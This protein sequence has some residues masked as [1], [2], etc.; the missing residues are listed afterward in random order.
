MGA[1]LAVCLST[2]MASVD[3]V[4]RLA[5]GFVQ[6]DDDA[7][8]LT[9]QDWRAFLDRMAEIKLGTLFVQRLEFVDKDGKFTPY[10]R[11]EGTDPTGEILRYADERGMKVFVGL[12]Q[13]ERWD[14]LRKQEVTIDALLEENKKLARTAWDK[15]KSHGSFKGWYLPQELAN[16]VFTADELDLLN[17]YFRSLSRHCR[18]LGDGRKDVAISPY[19]NPASKP[20]LTGPVDYGLNL[21]KILDGGEITVL[22]LQDS[23]GARDIKPVEFAAKVEPYY[24]EVKSLASETRRFWANV[25]SFEVGLTPTTFG[26]FEAQLRTARKY[27]ETIVTFDCY[28]YLNPLGFSHATSPQHKAAEA[29]LYADYK[30]AVASPR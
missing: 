3:P 14:T 17:G 6:L 23:V 8:K 12:R 24:R 28:H 15:Y 19:F 16:Y 11:A 10:H 9:P 5:G 4:P 2:L 13:D 29:K 22:M 30:Q 1:I 7:M 20:Y 18:G 21:K 27:A 26:R 25:E